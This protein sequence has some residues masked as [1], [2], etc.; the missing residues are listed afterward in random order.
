MKNDVT[1]VVVTYNSARFVRDCLKSLIA[2]APLLHSSQIVVVDNASKDDTVSI[3]KSDFPE[4]TLLES[5]E[6]VGFGRGNNLGM[7]HAPARYYY[8]HNADAYLQKNVLDQAINILDGAPHIGV[9]G[10][11]LV[12]P[13]MSPQTGAYAFTTPLK[14]ALQ[15]LR[16]PAIA[17]RIASDPNLRWLHKPLATLPMARSFLRTHNGNAQTATKIALVDWVCGAALILREETRTALDGGFDPSIFLYGED[18][19]LCIEARKSGWN[20]A[21]LPVTPVIHEFGWGS[22]GKASREVARLKADSLK[23]FIN[24]HFSRPGPSWAAMR[25]MLWIKRKS[26]RV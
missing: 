5:P 16:I 11:P 14:W 13:D 21:Q 9:A 15:G 12:F 3:I 22:S 6:N 10:L 26:W 7:A 8:L 25:A 18:E 23:V 4:V 2:N 1:V 19:D 20:V 24:K 17:R